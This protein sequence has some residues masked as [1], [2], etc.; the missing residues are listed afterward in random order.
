MS[1]PR[2]FD[3]A[4]YAK[5]RARAE[6]T[7]DGS[8]L[9]ADAAQTLFERVSAV[10]RTFRR[11]IDIGSRRQSFVR[12]RPLAER[13]T[14]VVPDAA[15]NSS[16]PDVVTADEECLPFA[17]ASF[18]LVV[19]I[20]SLH[21]ANDLPGV[22]FQI[23][24]LL[25]EDGLFVGAILGGATLQELRRAFAVGETQMLGGMSPRVA[26]FADVRDVGGL[27]QR[28]GFALPVADLERLTV[29]YEHFLTL[30]GDL[31]ALG[32]T[33]ALME[34]SRKPLQRSTLAAALHAYAEHDSEPDG[35]LRATFDVIYL[36]G[37]AASNPQPTRRNS[38]S[39]PNEGLDTALARR[40]A[41]DQGRFCA[42]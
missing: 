30:A 24:R 16:E 18:D 8:F 12:L 20:L 11:A 42:I 17:E 41:L 31:R 35:K 1:P 2:I 19:S 21:A 9:V 7:H 14:R 32:E 36:T 3:R 10:N 13:W 37:W 15:Q 23:R 22:L 28:A 27:L 38:E 33:N 6:R 26:P 29:R 25:V 39:R 34:R 4:I 5:R 40:L